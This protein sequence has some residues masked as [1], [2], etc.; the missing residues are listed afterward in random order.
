MSD[1]VPELMYAQLA[2]PVFAVGTPATADAVSWVGGATTRTPA[3]RAAR[4]RR[5]PPKSP[6][7]RGD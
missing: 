5:F 2:L 7:I 6:E 4:K 3:R 1:Q